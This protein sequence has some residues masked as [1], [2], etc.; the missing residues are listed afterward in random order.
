MMPTRY[1][2]LTKDFITEYHPDDIP[3]HIT[4]AKGWHGNQVGTIV[5]RYGRGKAFQPSSEIHPYFRRMIKKYIAL[6]PEPQYNFRYNFHTRVGY[7][8]AKFS[9]RWLDEFL[10]KYYD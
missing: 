3:A 6:F 1:F 5:A 10:M 2:H 7:N 9:E 8:V 4:E